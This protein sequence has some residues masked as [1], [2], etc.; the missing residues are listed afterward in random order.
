MNVRIILSV[1]NRNGTNIL[2]KRYNIETDLPRMRARVK[3]KNYEKTRFDFF[4]FFCFAAVPV[5]TV[6]RLS[7]CKFTLTCALR[8]PAATVKQ[9]YTAR[10]AYNNNNNSM[11]RAPRHNG[12]AA[13]EQLLVW[14]PWRRLPPPSPRRYTTSARNRLTRLSLPVRTIPRPHRV[15]TATVFEVRRVHRGSRAPFSRTNDNHRNN[16]NIT[17]TIRRHNINAVVAVVM[18]SNTA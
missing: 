2:L 4:F 1:R 6:P 12:P 9:V 13:T 17:G 15:R 11:A 5:V 14:R 7:L 3:P 8:I 10:T 16:I 18:P